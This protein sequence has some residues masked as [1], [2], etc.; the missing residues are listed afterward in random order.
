MH[1]SEELESYMS[2]IHNRGFAS[3]TLERRRE[4]AGKGGRAA[5]AAGVAHEYNSE[6]AREAGRRGGR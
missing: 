2:K 5:H 4:V 1:T 6:T 3:M